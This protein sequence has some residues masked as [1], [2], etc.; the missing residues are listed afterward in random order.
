MVVIGV[1]LAAVASFIGSAVLYGA[2]PVAAMVSRTSTPARG[3]PSRNR[4][5]SCCSED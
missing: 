3:C 5:C 1:A 2:P 4:C